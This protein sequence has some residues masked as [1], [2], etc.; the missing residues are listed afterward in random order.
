[1]EDSRVE[2][3]IPMLAYGTWKIENGAPTTEAVLTAMECGYRH[4]DTAAGYGN[5]FA[6]GKAIKNVV[7]PVR[8]FLLLINCGILIEAVRKQWL[9]ANVH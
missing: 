9:P 5:D 6:V 4:I 2:N 3:N 8:S 7:F 1:M